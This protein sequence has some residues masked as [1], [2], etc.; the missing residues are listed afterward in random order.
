MIYGYRRDRKSNHEFSRLKQNIERG[1]F[2]PQGK[3]S[4]PKSLADQFPGPKKCSPKRYGSKLKKRPFVAPKGD[5]VLNSGL[6]P[7]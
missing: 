3:G 7:S 5:W 6:C 4:I 1:K 2:D